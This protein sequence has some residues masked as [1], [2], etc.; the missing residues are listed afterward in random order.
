MLTNNS[1]NIFAWT[2][3]GLAQ[4]K[5]LIKYV[6]DIRHVPS[7]DI[8]ANGCISSNTNRVQSNKIMFGSAHMMTWQ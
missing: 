1:C 3:V 2:L 8:T 4:F 6:S 7:V 5:A